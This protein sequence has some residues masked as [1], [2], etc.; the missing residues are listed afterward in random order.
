MFTVALVA[1]CDGDNSGAPVTDKTFG[2]CV[3]NRFAAY[4][5]TTGAVNLDQLLLAGEK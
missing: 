1:N 5:L 2:T 4:Y 3:E